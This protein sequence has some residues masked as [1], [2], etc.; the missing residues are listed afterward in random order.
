IAKQDL[1]EAEIRAACGAAVADLAARS[2][3]EGGILLLHDAAITE[4]LGAAALTTRIL[5]P[6]LL[7]ALRQR[8]LRGIA[9]P[10]RASAP[11]FGRFLFRASEPYT[12]RPGFSAPPRAST[13]SAAAGMA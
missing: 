5:L 1:P 6:Q 3:L 8:G 4:P 11:A 10:T 2:D 7:P 13:P 12:V 9:L